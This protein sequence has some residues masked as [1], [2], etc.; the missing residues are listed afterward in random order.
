MRIP[1]K[2]ATYSGN[3]F[4]IHPSSNSLVECNTKVAGLR[5]LFGYVFLKESPSSS[6]L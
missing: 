1:A 2:T 6:I 4:T 5:Q 3:N